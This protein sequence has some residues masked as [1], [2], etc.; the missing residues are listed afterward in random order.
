MT[1][2]LAYSY[3]N[4]LARK[5]T[6]GLT[7]FGVGLVVFVFCAILMLSNGMKTTLVSTGSDDNAIVIRRAATT[8]I[9][10]IVS[11]NIAD[12]VKADPGVAREPDGTPLFT[13]E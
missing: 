4:S 12:I 3:K 13:N 11:R 7:V 8:E 6:S 1:K 9:V 10:S 2:L 5:L